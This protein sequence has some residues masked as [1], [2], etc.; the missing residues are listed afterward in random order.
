MTPLLLTTAVI[1][2]TH[3]I[4]LLHHEVME[5]NLVEKGYSQDEA[6]TMTSMKHNYKREA[7]V[8]YDKNS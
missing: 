6:H 8:Y 1:L 7:D 4:T 5:R 2:L 3:D